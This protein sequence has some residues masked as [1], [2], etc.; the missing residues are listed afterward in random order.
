M[1]LLCWLSHTVQRLTYLLLL[2]LL[3]PG[4]LDTPLLL[5]LP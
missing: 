3:V 2:L 5:L 4:S 1:L